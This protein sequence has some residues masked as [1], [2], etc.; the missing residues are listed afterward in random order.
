MQILFYEQE[1]CKRGTKT[2]K[3]LLGNVEYNDHAGFTIR[4]EVNVSTVKITEAKRENMS[5]LFKEQ[6]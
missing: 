3:L 6:S 4:I 1:V 5:L 2:V